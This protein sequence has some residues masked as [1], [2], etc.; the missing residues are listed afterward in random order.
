MTWQRGFF[1]LWVL[2]V[3][4]WLAGA[5]AI[6]APQGRDEWHKKGVLDGLDAQKFEVLIPTDCSLGRGRGGKLQDKADYEQRE[7]K[8]WYDLSNFRRLYPEYNDKT[9]EALVSALYAKAG[10]ILTPP[11]PFQVLMQFLMI[12]IGVPLVVLALGAGLDWVL[13]GFKAARL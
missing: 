13:R 11:K 3:V 1:R 8:C 9:D 5:I 4:V 7:G 2:L 6:F 12:G 10:I